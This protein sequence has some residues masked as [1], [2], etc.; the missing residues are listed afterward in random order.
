MWHIDVC[1]CVCVGIDILLSDKKEWN[2]AICSN[3]DEPR[4]DNT[5]KVSQTGKRHLYVDS[6]KRVQMTLFAE[7]K[8][9]HR[10]WKQGYGYQRE[11]VRGG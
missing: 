5:N 3:M 6:R 7:Q 10:L 11:Q 1:V 2:N 8:Q 4:D 9:T